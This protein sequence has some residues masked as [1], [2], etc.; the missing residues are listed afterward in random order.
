MS[1][2]QWATD[3]T[4][5]EVYLPTAEQWLSELA[6]TILGLGSNASMEEITSELCGRRHL[7][8][9]PQLQWLAEMQSIG[10]DAGLVLGGQG[11][12]NFVEGSDGDIIVVL[13]GYGHTKW[14]AYPILF[15]D[16]RKWNSETRIIMNNCDALTI[17]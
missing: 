4:M 1:N 10:N 7:I 8:K 2:I 9:L 13:L 12:I 15:D 5:V 14:Y 17:Y 16:R 11:N 6:C 3:N